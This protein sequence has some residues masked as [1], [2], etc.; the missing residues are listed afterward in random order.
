MG[1]LRCGHDPSSGTSMRSRVA[2]LNPT[3]ACLHI[4]RMGCYIS[5]FSTC[6]ISYDDRREQAGSGNL[7][8]VEAKYP[9]A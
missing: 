1:Q 9:K 6:I 3:M 4:H 5:T 8:A 7:L 2:K